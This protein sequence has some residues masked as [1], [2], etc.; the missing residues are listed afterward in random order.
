SVS[1]TVRWVNGMAKLGHEV[2]LITMHEEEADKI[3][4]RVTI[5]HLKIP[6]PFGYYL[7]VS[8]AKRLLK[9]IQPDLLHVHYASGYGTLARFINFTPTLLSVWGTDVYIFPYESKQKERILR[10]NLKAA[11]FIT[12]TSFDMR[13]QTQ[14]FTSKQIEVI[15]FGIDT[16]LFHPTERN[17]VETIVIGTVK[18][19]EHVYGID[20][21]IK[22][23]AFLI[24]KLR[25]LGKEHLADR[26]R[27]KIVG[28]GPQLKELKDLTQ[29]Y[30]MDSITDFVGSV[31]N[32]EVPSYLNQID[33]ITAF[34][35]SESFGV[36]VIVASECELTVIV[37]DVGGL[38]EV[39]QQGE[40][41]YS[42]PLEHMD[43]IVKK[44][45]R[46]VIHHEQR[47]QIGKKGR[48]FVKQHYM[49]EK[50][51]L[52]MEKIYNKLVNNELMS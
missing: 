35:R 30:R 27:L 5:H 32:E 6:A 21:L 3:D 13:S 12:S 41:G 23:T 33:I 50:N 25:E 42:I 19:L 36:A 28:K 40:T 44:L 43:E 24:N 10:K 18:K 17:D 47:I 1:H 48:L 11:D 31:P 14:K 15:P 45:A 22:A 38:Q 9:I 4:Q 39:V 46:L 37:S 7:N 29:E 16:N 26:I 49:W 51:V 34:S 8:K 20:I 52:Q 2:H